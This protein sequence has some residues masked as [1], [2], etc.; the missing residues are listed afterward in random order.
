[1]SELEEK[2]NALKGVKTQNEETIAT[3]QEQMEQA[4]LWPNKVRFG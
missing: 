3:L 1:V 2:V 4:K